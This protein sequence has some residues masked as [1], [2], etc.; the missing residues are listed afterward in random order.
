MD[1]TYVTAA[2]GALRPEDARERESAGAGGAFDLFLNLPSE[3][4][5]VEK[6][7]AQDRQQDRSREDLLAEREAASREVLERRSRR[8]D[9]DR[10]RRT[11]SAKD[12]SDRARRKESERLERLNERDD[13][14]AQMLDRQ[15]DL[16]PAAERLVD[17]E[18]SQ[19]RARVESE[20]STTAH[21]EPSQ[22]D[23][24]EKQSQQIKVADNS[25]G[26]KPKG[27]EADAQKSALQAI[28]A[29]RTAAEAKVLEQFNADK[30]LAEKT[31]AQEWS[32]LLDDSR[33]SAAKLT[34]QSSSAQA[35]AL[36]ASQLAQQEALKLQSQQL[37]DAQ[38]RFDA[39]QKLS[40]GQSQTQ[41]AA[42]FIMDEAQETLQNKAGPQFQE[43]RM[44]GE[45]LSEQNRS[46]SHNKGTNAN[47][48]DAKLNEPNAD[49]PDANEWARLF[50][51]NANGAKGGG[52]KAAGVGDSV[53]I[54]ASL[55]GL[56]TDGSAGRGVVNAGVQDLPSVQLK[57]TSSVASA[58]KSQSAG[59]PL[60]E[61]VDEMAIL[62]QISDGL[63]LKPGRNHTAT[64]RL[65]PAELGQVQVKVQVEGAT[66]RIL[67]NTEH[68]AV[69]DLVSSQLDQLRR[70]ILAQGVQVT[71]LEVRNEL[72]KHGGRDEHQSGEREEIDEQEQ[73]VEKPR[74]RAR[75]GDGQID[76][77]A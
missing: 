14:Y 54:G 19:S 61:G 5:A 67:V 9:E 64:I 42:E 40:Q 68:A 47:Q 38:G 6:S 50:Q 7:A 70:D 11:Q 73:V 34:Q 12:A 48:T 28:L 8:R 39:N 55:K 17:D 18:A 4:G 21:K 46:S 56:G 45:L 66:A 65:N 3:L 27:G 35:D 31:A 69:G 41:V 63:K 32:K 2:Q 72:G 74:L 44:S 77:Q 22:D 10:D 26:Q 30:D 15:S 13:E 1:V 23:S 43:S 76:V 60:P 71:H 49:G 57:N 53:Q 59:Q 25:A 33:N 75:R 37:L 24:G 29:E 62:R 52:V 20:K 36:A 58:S 51:N 16:V